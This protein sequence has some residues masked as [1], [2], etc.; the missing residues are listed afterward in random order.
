MT[1]RN[2]AGVYQKPNGFWEYRFIIVVDGKKI[3][4]KK[5]TD[6]SGNKLKTKRER[7][8]EIERKKVKEVFQEYCDEGR[9]GK[10]YNTILKQD[11]L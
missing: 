9:S 2:D 3:S 1:K 5:G 7:K 10:A 8:R 6:E 4:K 11:S